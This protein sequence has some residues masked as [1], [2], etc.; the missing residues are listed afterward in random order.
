MLKLLRNYSIA[1]VLALSALTSIAIASGDD[2]VPPAAVT[3]PNPFDAVQQMMKTITSLPPVQLNANQSAR[4]KEKLP[5][6]DEFANQ[7]VQFWLYANEA[8][9][10]EV[11]FLVVDNCLRGKTGPIPTA[12]LTPILNGDPV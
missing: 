12:I 7:D 3:C 1:I 11:L 2:I 5:L 6:P 10:Q 9:D 4:V 8:G